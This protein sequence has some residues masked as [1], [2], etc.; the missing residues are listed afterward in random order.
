MYYYLMYDFLPLPVPP[1]AAQPACA[2]ARVLSRY[3]NQINK[4][5]IYIYIVYLYYQTLYNIV[6]SCLYNINPL[7]GTARRRS[8]LENTIPLYQRL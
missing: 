6:L 7:S 1:K 2:S 5:Y 8:R 4:Q 3:I